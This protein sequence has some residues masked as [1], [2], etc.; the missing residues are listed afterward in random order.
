MIHWQC[1]R[2]SLLKKGST[3]WTPEPVHQGATVDV[4]VQSKRHVTGLGRKMEEAPFW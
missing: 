2:L 4:Y 3:I 1:S